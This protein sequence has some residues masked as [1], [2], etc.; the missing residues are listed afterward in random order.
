M[1]MT[2][3]DLGSSASA[4]ERGVDAVSALQ[5]QATRM[6]K[7]RPVAVL[8]AALGAGYIIGRLLSRK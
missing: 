3:N 2:R 5:A 8:L 4:L 7:E 1:D 6:I